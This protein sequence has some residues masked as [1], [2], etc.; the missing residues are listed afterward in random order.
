MVIIT[1]INLSH[2]NHLDAELSATYSPFSWLRLST[3][4]NFYQYEQFGD[5]DLIN[6][7]TKDN[8]WSARINS[9]LKFKKG[10]AIQGSFRYQGENQSGQYYSKPQYSLDFGIS[11]DILSDKGNI[12]L[13]A[14]N[15]LDSQEERRVTSGIGYQITTSSKRYGQRISATFSYRFNRNKNYCERRG[16]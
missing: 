15:L 14:R 8:T 5:Y 9:N 13:N 2:E 6:Y 11:K 3:D 7:D 1:P 4:F 12:S 16:G 10:P